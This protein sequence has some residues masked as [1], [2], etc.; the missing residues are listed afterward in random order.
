MSQANPFS[1]TRAVDFSDLQII[2]QW[3]E[4]PGDG[5]VVALAKPRSEMPML[6][7]GGKGSGKTHLMRYL[8]TKVQLASGA[9]AKDLLRQNHLGI[10]LRCTGINAARFNN[11]G[12]DLILWREV[13]GYHMELT[14]AE[15]CLRTSQL[16]LQEAG[17]QLSEGEVSQIVSGV[18]S[19]FD[20]WQ[21][22][23]PKS[24]TDLTSSLANIRRSVD[25][26]VNNCSQR[27]PLD[28]SLLATPAQLVFGVPST[29]ASLDVFKSFLFVYL[30]DELENLDENKQ[31]FVNSLVRDN[32][33]PCS[34][35]VG[36]KLYGLK[37]KGTLS[38]G[39]ELKAGSE[40]EPLMLDEELRATGEAKY[41][42][43]VAELCKRRLLGAGFMVPD[44]G[45]TE[46]W[47]DGQFASEPSGPLGQSET[48][49][50]LRGE[51]GAKG[52]P[53]ERPWMKRLRFYL[54]TAAVRGYS[55]IETKD[56][57]SVLNAV[58]CQSHPLLERLNVHLLYQS[59]NTRSGLVV[60]GRRI[61]KDCADTIAGQ[62]PKKYKQSLDHWGSD[63]LAHI[64]RDYHREQLYVGFKSLVTMTFGL[65]RHLLVLLKHIFDA[66][67][68]RGERPFAGGIIS[69]E[70]QRVGVKRAAEWFF[71]DARMAG[72]DGDRLQTCVSRLAQLMRA[73]RFSDKPSEVSVSAF[74]VDLTR[75]ST[76]TRTMIDLAEKWSLLSKSDGGRKE[77]NSFRVDSQYQ[78]NP[79]LAPRWDLPIA[80]RGVLSVTPAE[81]DVLFNPDALEDAVKEVITTRTLR[82]SGPRFSAKH[83]PQ[84]T[85][86]DVEEDHE[87]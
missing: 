69:V 19:L 18:V 22:E 31:V 83:D 44:V 70:A 33:P 41:F 67:E 20:T 28:V 84:P 56:V 71:G 2:R 40:Y 26:Q 37:T 8:S 39:E 42:G 62:K 12:Q 77:K 3:V 21:Q 48:G 30:I 46:G 36:S 66:S 7:L 38:D 82:M 63:L 74:S 24:L 85:L 57:T 79:L 58:R 17:I 50:V 86:F 68:F 9:S 64:R 5:G 27:R 55:K 10:Y 11:K 60:E 65:P 78:L 72:V 6:I 87:Y 80:L 35:K 29:L 45:T 59:W 75:V 47:L 14:L 1:V 23:L 13:F 81:A 49:F 25:A 52:S 53:P 51:E 34:I 32:R 54:N 43:F 16:L 73:V 15:E 61:Q 4:L 76:A